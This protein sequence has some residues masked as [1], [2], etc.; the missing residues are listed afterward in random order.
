MQRL[1]RWILFTG[2]VL[3]PILADARPAAAMERR[4]FSPTAHTFRLLVIPFDFTDDTHRA[5]IPN[6][7]PWQT[8][9]I[10]D[11]AIFG[12]GF[13]P[14]GP[15][16]RR[17]A[18]GSVAD[19]IASQLP[20]V[21]FTG[22]IYHYPAGA[23]T[24]DGWYQFT[25]R[26]GD[27][28][29]PDTAFDVADDGWN[30]F[31]RTF[32]GRLDDH[33]NGTTLARGYDAV[34]MLH[35]GG[36]GSVR[37]PFGYLL[38]SGGLENPASG[39]DDTPRYDW[40]GTF[41]HEVG[42]LVTGLPDFYGPIWEYCTGWDLLSVGNSLG[43]FPA[44][45]SAWLRHAVGLSR[46]EQRM[47]KGESG[48]V[49]LP[50]PSPTSPKQMLVLDNSSLGNGDELVAEYRNHDPHDDRYD[51]SL[52]GVPGGNPNGLLI[53]DYDRLMRGT[54]F[55]NDNVKGYLPQAFGQPNT[56]DAPINQ[57]G[58][59]L[60]TELKRQDGNISDDGDL[61]GAGQDLVGSHPEDDALRPLRGS[62]NRDGDVVWELRDLRQERGGFSFDAR[63]QGRG[64]ADEA[65]GVGARWTSATGPMDHG[66]TL[67]PVT[68]WYYSQALY[69]AS[70]DTTYRDNLWIAT[71][72]G[73]AAGAHIAEG[74]FGHTIAPTGEHLTGSVILPPGGGTRLILQVTYRRHQFELLNTT[75]ADVNHA[76]GNRAPQFSVDLTAWA[77][78][79]IDLTLRIEAP[80]P[81]DVGLVGAY[82]FRKAE[83]VLYDAVA[84]A[85]QGRA[86][87]DPVDA[88]ARVTNP[89]GI[90]G[91]R[92]N[93]MLEDGVTYDR[94]LFM[95]P[96]SVARGR[97]VFVSRPIYVP[98]SG[99]ILRGTVGYPAESIGRGDGA[100]FRLT[101]D[102]GVHRLPVRQAAP[103][104]LQVGDTFVALG[105]HDGAPRFGPD[106]RWGSGL[107]W[108]GEV[109]GAWSGDWLRSGDFD[110]DG[111]DDI[112]VFTGG[113][114][115]RVG[116]ALSTG[117]GFAQPARWHDHFLTDGERPLVGHLDRDNK[118]DIVAFAQNGDAYVATSTG[119]GFTAG[120]RWGGGLAYPNTVPVLGDVNGDGLDDVVLF[121]KWQGYSRAPDSV[122]VALNHGG[123][124]FEAP[125]HWPGPCLRLSVPLVG[126]L[127]NDGRADV[128]CVDEREG[129]TVRVALST[130]TGF[131][132]TT[133]WLEG[134]APRQLDGA[135][136]DRPI[137]PTPGPQP[138][139]GAIPF[140]ARAGGVTYLV[141][142]N[143][144]ALNA[145]DG[146]PSEGNVWAAAAQGDHFATPRRWH[147]RFAVGGQWPLVGDF[148]GD[149]RF[150]IAA[151]DATYPILE[152]WEYRAIT[153][154]GHGPLYPGDMYISPKKANLPLL[155]QSGP[156][157][158]RFALDLY[159]YHG[160]DVRLELTVD[161]GPAADYDMVMWPDLKL[162]QKPLAL[163]GDTTGRIHRTAPP[164]VIVVRSGGP[165]TFRR[166]RPLI[167][168][169]PP[170]VVLRPGARI[171][172]SPARA[173]A[174][175]STKRR[176]PAR[177]TATATP[178]PAKPGATAT[179]GPPEPTSAPMPTQGAKAPVAPTAI[180]PTTIAAATPRVATPTPTA[181]SASAPPTAPPPGGT[182]VPAPTSTPSATPS[183]TATATASPT[184]LVPTA[185]SAPSATPSATAS[186][187]ATAT[188]TASPTTTP[189]PPPAVNDVGA[190]PDPVY[191]GQCGTL[192]TSLTVRA[193]VTSHAG[194]PAVTLRYRY[195]SGVPGAA[196]GPY[197]TAPLAPRKDGAFAATV[198]VGN[199]AYKD[200][201]G[202]NG[203][204]DYQVTATDG[205]G[206]SG[207]S[208]PRSV[209][210]QY[211][212]G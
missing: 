198:D 169:Q 207:S 100:T 55:S 71:N 27:E 153:D 4:V 57:Y 99:A 191:Y 165:P 16:G 178:R 88:N 126:D 5:Q 80:R 211:C 30:K 77:G 160:R 82:F 62:A 87:A 52:A 185:T 6:H 122:W 141:W 24:R 89:D 133:T 167:D 50:D 200:T 102:D 106:A 146:D 15:D 193:S 51:T 172:T 119:A 44:P 152:P 7:R 182:A 142:F 149:G 85:G 13:V 65:A 156:R 140:L 108:S 3:L 177:P 97:A 107:G 197:H 25:P 58:L 157:L 67:R 147:D 196:P 121:T 74:H 189:V 56:E 163:L 78:R 66:N 203:T 83:R 132:P 45:I 204:V 202:A 209:G 158:N 94:A 115:P 110:G 166:G 54:F 124:S 164:A 41:Q 112:A 33:T 159:A 151:T 81:A 1:Y 173:A 46:V 179:A 28:F 36:G 20:G 125:R 101:L 161:A 76:V 40:L 109:G 48:R 68:G 35:G 10:L 69:Q 201:G 53:A 17:Q 114:H 116:V 168:T 84:S 130:G 145:R 174:P 111:R 175:K 103:P 208:T 8:H 148:D 73:G 128:A 92:Q 206:A 60:V 117:H 96:Q 150:D 187:T 63:F 190:T 184:P 123:A 93:V 9:E 39:H 91:R 21:R 131:Q 75:F 192:P 194:T 183:A 139:A 37:A 143:R 138:I 118:S 105:A 23:P 64:L 61:F 31:Y 136:V 95:R 129:G 49:F 18:S 11:R 195:V 70:R 90:V 134:D 181:G 137:D 98:D 47:G 113:D 79:H 59:S 104:L 199:E 120:A 12:H 155:G 210:L 34:Y 127:N 32:F 186:S 72:R 86:L 176:P 205:S 162:Y 2:L 170:V 26:R 42:H 14:A 180:P 188:A 19:Y 38:A 144:S 171:P 154:N 135:R 29:G 212:P 22:D 43:G